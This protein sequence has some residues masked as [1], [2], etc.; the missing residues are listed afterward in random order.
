MKDDSIGSAYLLKINREDIHRFS[1]GFSV[2]RPDM[3]D[4]DFYSIFLQSFQHY[5][6]IIAEERDYF[7]E[8]FSYLKLGDVTSALGAYVI[9]LD[10]I[11]TGMIGTYY[12]DGYCYNHQ[13][14]LFWKIGCVF[15][16]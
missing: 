5:A 2:H 7:L 9:E 15:R 6:E 1:M 14:K 10:W 3:D 12:F 16:K 8:N 13:N 4:E 11:E